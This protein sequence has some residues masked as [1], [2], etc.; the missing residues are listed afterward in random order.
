MFFQRF[1]QISYFQ[2][3]AITTPKCGQCKSINRNE[4]HVI[5][6]NVLIQCYYSVNSVLAYY[7]FHYIFIN[8][9][10]TETNATRH[11]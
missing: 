7:T 5:K 4:I 9:S 11:N 3:F 6:T 2:V 10:M 8:Q 1:V